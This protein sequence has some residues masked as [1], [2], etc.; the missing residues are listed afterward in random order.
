[1]TRGGGTSGWSFP[2]R[3]HPFES[4]QPTSSLQ[5][6]DARETEDLQEDCRLVLTTGAQPPPHPLGH[7]LKFDAG[8]MRRSVGVQRHECLGTDRCRRERK[9]KPGCQVRSDMR[10][11][12]EMR[13]EGGQRRLRLRRRLRH[14]RSWTGE[15]PPKTGSA[16]ARGVRRCIDR[17]LSAWALLEERETRRTDVQSV[18]V[19]RCCCCRERGGGEEAIRVV[20]DP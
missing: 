8:H 12:L 9:V 10:I 4:Q 16:Y 19:L 11:R 20:P 1:M 17:R 13:R 2:N 5:P 14:G 7:I 6:N 3:I 18:F 15:Q